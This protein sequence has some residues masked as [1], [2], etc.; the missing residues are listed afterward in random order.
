MTPSGVDEL[1]VREWFERARNDELNARAILKDRDGT[2]TLVC[3]LSQQ[4][5]EKFLKGALVYFTGDDVEKTHA[6][7]RLGRLLASH[8]PEIAEHAADLDRLSEYYVT[9][10]YPSDVPLESFTWEHAE[11]ALAAAQKLAEIVGR[12]IKL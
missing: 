6:L 4:L 3:F 10:R 5:A 2:P 8:V 9:T 1:I 12:T 7:R 11:A